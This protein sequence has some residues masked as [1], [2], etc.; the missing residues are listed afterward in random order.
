M[1]CLSRWPR[2]QKIVV[3]VHLFR[4]MKDVIGGTILYVQSVKWCTVI[5]SIISIN[6]FLTSPK[7]LMKKNSKILLVLTATPLFLL[8]TFGGWSISDQGTYH[9]VKDRSTSSNHIFQQV[10]TSVRIFATLCYNPNTLLQF[11]GNLFE[12][13]REWYHFVASCT[14]IHFAFSHKAPN[15]Y[16]SLEFLSW[17]HSVKTITISFTINHSCVKEI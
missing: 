8:N 7:A 13:V 11:C 12:G 10:C 17:Y 14:G 6:I 4:H 1:H 15:L 3:D 2:P 16:M 9:I 5:G